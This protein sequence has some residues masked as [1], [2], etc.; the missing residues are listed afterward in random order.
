MH[1]NGSFGLPFLLALAL[2]VCFLGQRARIIQ[3][4]VLIEICR[5]NAVTSRP[6]SPC[7][8]PI[9]SD[10]VADHR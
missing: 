6:A 10:A 8:A 4:W 1:E 7:N 3:A 2:L 5:D 9:A